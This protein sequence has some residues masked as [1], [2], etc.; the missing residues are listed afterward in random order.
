MSHIVSYLR[1]TA[2]LHPWLFPPSAL[3]RSG[4]NAKIKL[5]TRRK[6]KVSPSI[7]ICSS[8]LR[9]EDFMPWNASK[10]SQP[11]ENIS[12]STKRLLAGLKGYGLSSSSAISLN[13]PSPTEQDTCQHLQI[14]WTP[15]PKK[16]ANGNNF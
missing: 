5:H 8:Q 6:H 12:A 2:L 10:S 3:I 11:S 4:F 16:I 13:Y 15:E 9:V 1:H 14:H 7:K